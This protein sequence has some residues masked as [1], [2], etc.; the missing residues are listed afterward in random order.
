MVMLI[1]NVNGRADVYSV[2]TVFIT[3]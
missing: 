3:D 2:L 1:I